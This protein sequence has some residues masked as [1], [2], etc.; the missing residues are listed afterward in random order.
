[1]NETEGSV[2]NERKSK[3]R[4]VAA[5]SKIKQAPTKG[6]KQCQPSMVCTH[7]KKKVLVTH[8]LPVP[9]GLSMNIFRE[10]MPHL[11]VVYVSVSK[12]F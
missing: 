12:I 11:F 7:C 6:P 10:P 9:S 5:N 2:V 1:M 4:R 3:R 8:S